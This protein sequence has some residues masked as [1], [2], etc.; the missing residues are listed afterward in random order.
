MRIG[1]LGCGNV[2]SAFVQLVDRQADAIEARTGVRLEVVKVA[3]RN[4]SNGVSTRISKLDIFK[5]VLA[6]LMQ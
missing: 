1:V 5:I 3:V 6:S 4:V 2:G